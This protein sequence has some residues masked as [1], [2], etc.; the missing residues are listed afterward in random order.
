MAGWIA[1]S[2]IARKQTAV[3]HFEK[4]YEFGGDDY[5]AKAAF[6]LGLVYL[7]NQNKTKA[8]D[9]FKRANVNNFSYYGQNASLKI[10]EF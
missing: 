10:S 6:W 2:F 9:W 3:K 7:E 8:I 1:F 4:V 5:K